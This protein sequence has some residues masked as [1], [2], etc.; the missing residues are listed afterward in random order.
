MNFFM[1][2]PMFIGSSQ[3]FPEDSRWLSPKILKGMLAIIVTRQATI[4]CAYPALH[5]LSLRANLCISAYPVS[6]ILFLCS[7][8]E[9]RIAANAG[10]HHPRGTP[11]CRGLRQ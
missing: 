9:Q 10:P 11:H 7:F 4:A 8:K 6:V 2:K 1:M 3:P 5:E